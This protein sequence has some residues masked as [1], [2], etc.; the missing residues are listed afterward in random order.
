VREWL[1]GQGSLEAVR[2][3]LDTLSPTTARYTALTIGRKNLPP[4]MRHQFAEVI[5]DRPWVRSG[6]RHIDSP[7]WWRR[8][9]T[10]RLLADL[11]THEDEHYVRRLL[12]DRHPAVRAAATTCLRRVANAAIIEV[13]L[14]ELPAQPVV[15]QSYQLMLLREQWQL[16]R[17]AILPRLSADHTAEQLAHWVLVAEALETPDVLGRVVTLHQHAA[18]SVRIGVARALKKYFHPDS[19]RV[20]LTL[21]DDADWRV[22]AQA[23]RSLGVLRDGLAVEPLAHRLTDPAWW[24]RFRSALALS[25]LGEPGRAALRAARDKPDRFA[26]NMAV[27]VSGLSS[28]SI[29]E[30]VEG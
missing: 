22:R 24:V 5:R 26:A 18:P 29:I 11:G 2:V 14:D 19:V 7:W 8:L 15:V 17:D 20:L 9:D 21:L 4:E 12:R 3:A 28:G 13:V 23:A 1:V 25:Q 10:A 6:L 16:A 30:L 27:L